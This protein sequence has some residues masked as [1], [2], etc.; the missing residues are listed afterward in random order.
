MYAPHNI[1][2]KRTNSPPHTQPIVSKGSKATPYNAPTVALVHRLVRKAVIVEWL[3]RVSLPSLN[4]SNQK[5]PNVEP[6]SVLSGMPYPKQVAIYIRGIM[7]KVYILNL[8]I[9]AAAV[10]ETP[11]KRRRQFFEVFS[12]PAKAHNQPHRGIV[13]NIIFVI[14]TPK[15]VI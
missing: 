3:K 1:V 12:A 10:M 9:R 11:T 4:R 8:I 15:P 13:N 2:F 5:R 6:V 7:R 14:L